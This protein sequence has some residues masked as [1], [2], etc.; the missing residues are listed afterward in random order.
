M[1]DPCIPNYAILAFYYIYSYYVLQSAVLL[2]F[3]VSGSGLLPVVSH[4]YCDANH[5]SLRTLQ[6]T[7]MMIS[8]DMFV[9]ETHLEANRSKSMLG[10]DGSH[11]EFA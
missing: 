10:A 6:E 11:C 8:V 1:I 7:M 2:S 4:A 5:A 3:Y 9:C